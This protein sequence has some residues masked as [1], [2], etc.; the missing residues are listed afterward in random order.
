M[1]V[2]LTYHCRRARQDGYA[3]YKVSPQLPR[4]HFVDI[5]VTGYSYRGF[6]RPKDM[7][8]LSAAEALRRLRC[9]PELIG[10]VGALYN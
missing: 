10:W 6:H 2:F 8:F 3:A 5:S 1:T 4:V 9:Q 7:M